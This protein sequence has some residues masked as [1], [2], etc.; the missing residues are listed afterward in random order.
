MVE[1]MY[2]AVLNVL[3]ASMLV[4][5]LVGVG[6]C[7]SAV[8]IDPPAEPAWRF[9]TVEEFLTK[10]PQVR[11]SNWEGDRVEMG[12]KTVGLLEYTGLNGAGMATQQTAMQ[13]ASC[14]RAGKLRVVDRTRLS[15]IE[16]QLRLTVDGWEKLSET[17]RAK[18]VGQL[19][20]ADFFLAGDVGEFKSDNQMIVLRAK[21]NP[22]EIEKYETEFAAF[23]TRLN[24]ELKKLDSTGEQ[25]TPL[26][27]SN[28][29]AKRFQLLS[30]QEKVK[31]PAAWRQDIE[32]RSRPENIQVS[33][34]TINTRLIDL[35][36][37]RAVWFFNGETSG[38][39]STDTMKNVVTQMLESLTTPPR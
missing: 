32:T 18:K 22:G 20:A 31:T 8:K 29:Q 28:T 36:T 27:I 2:R 11:E 34:V 10:Y 30:L 37:G 16:K 19:Q 6:G 39:G 4:V 12:G 5:W 38:V 13:M 9:E 24:D 15:E 14:E 7:S 1:S 21:F 17:E 23:S 26:W 33:K 25:L 3:A 35:R